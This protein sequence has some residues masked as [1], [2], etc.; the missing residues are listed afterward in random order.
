MRRLSLFAIVVTLAT[1]CDVAR[2]LPPSTDSVNIG[3]INVGDF[4]LQTMAYKVSG[5]GITPLEGTISLVDANATPSAFI[6]GIPPGRQYLLELDASSDDGSGQ[7]Y[8]ASAFDV[9]AG[10]SADVMI[11]LLC[12]YPTKVRTTMVD[13]MIDYCPSLASYAAAPPTGTVGGVPIALTA[14]A[15]SFYSDPP[16]FTWSASVGALSSETSSVT[17]YTCTGAGPVTLT[18]TVTDGVCPDSATLMVTCLPA[19]PLDAGD[20]GRGQDGGRL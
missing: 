12:S 16:M 15:F 5:N 13:G 17:S 19:A 11:S 1:A 4:S 20:G 3:F 8:G 18:V 7:C 6:G 2:D 14:T 10:Q 9:V